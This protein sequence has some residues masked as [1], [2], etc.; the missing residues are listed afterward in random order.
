MAFL[1]WNVLRNS[2]MNGE[3]DRLVTKDTHIKSVLIALTRMSR[4]SSYVDMGL[5]HSAVESPTCSCTVGALLPEL[6]ETT[7][8]AVKRGKWTGHVV[9]A[10]GL[11]TSHSQCTV[12]VAV[13]DVVAEKSLESGADR[14]WSLPSHISQRRWRV[15]TPD[16]PPQSSTLT[17]TSVQHPASHMSSRELTNKS[18]NLPGQ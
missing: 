6:R 17:G 3:R 11:P 1:L 10:P 2:D 16:I 18:N 14:G 15:S 8:A 5:C 9:S 13:V 7:G 4:I 12:S